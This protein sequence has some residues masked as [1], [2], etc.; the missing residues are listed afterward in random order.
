[1]TQAAQQ[2]LR[3]EQYEQG[4][5]I[6]E[7]LQWATAAAVSVTPLPAVD[8]I[9]AVAIHARMIAEL[10]SLYGSK[11]TF[12]Q[13]SRTAQ[14]LA[15]LLVQLGSVEL[16][17]QTLASLLKSSPAALVGIPIQA[18]SAAYLTRIAGLSYLDWLASGTPWQP[19]SL[20]ERI[21]T[22]L[23]AHSQKAFIQS[24]LQQWSGPKKPLLS[25]QSTSAP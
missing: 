22:Y 3:Q 19:D 7:R 17:T 6:V 11:I 9:A 23:K 18:A 15:R 25:D 4:C 5:A 16:V 21:Q 20:K 10:H 13:A 2:A 1:L 14:T 24:F 8:L 12:Q